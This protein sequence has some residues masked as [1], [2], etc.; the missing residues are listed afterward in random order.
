[1]V[2]AGQRSV[3]SPAVAKAEVIVDVLA[4][5]IDN[6]KFTTNAFDD[7]AYIAAIALVAVARGEVLAM[8][9]IV[10]LTIGDVLAGVQ[11]QKRENFE[12]SHGQVDRRAGPARAV[13]VE[14]QLETTEMQDI[15][16]RSDSGGRHRPH[17]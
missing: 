7:G 9:K 4:L 14:A 16:G 2:I 10:N 1:M 3:A 6:M 12:L 8:Y 5:R 17:T 13:D 11:R 15:A